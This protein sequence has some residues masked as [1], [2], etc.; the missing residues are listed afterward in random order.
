LLNDWKKIARHS[1]AASLGQRFAPQIAFVRRR[2]SP[3]GYLGLHLTIGALVLAGAAWLFV[4][5][6]EDVVT[7]DPLTVVDARVATW[8]H[9][10]ASPPL[11]RVMMSI[12]YL[13]APL[14]AIS[15]ALIV[16]LFFLWQRHWYRLL[17]LLLAVPGGALLNVLLKYSFRRGRPAFDDPLLTLHTYSFP[18]GHAMGATV[19]YGVLAAFAVWT[20]W[21]WRWRVLAAVLAGLL[22]L[23]ICFS[24]VY[25]GVHYLSDVLGGIVEG[26]A[27][28]VLCLTAVS[29]LRRRRMS[30]QVA[31]AQPERRKI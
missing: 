18:S 27:W 1:R 9:T 3:E 21:G 17:T 12:S 16:A 25:L 30:G 2:L 19:L 31:E 24:R 4:A 6:A 22:I 15:I 13:G 26:V 11:T 28:L 5:I 29:T 14:V 7:G 8:L 10:H 23:L 20:V